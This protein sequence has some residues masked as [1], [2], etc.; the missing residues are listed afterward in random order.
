[1]KISERYW[2]YVRTIA[3]GLVPILKEL[4]DRSLNLEMVIPHVY[5]THQIPQ[6][7]ERVHLALIGTADTLQL[8]NVESTK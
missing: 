8:N 7:F 3:E 6:H 1:M 4:M 5:L 2:I